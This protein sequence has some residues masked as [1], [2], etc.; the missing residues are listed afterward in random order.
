MK[1]LFYPFQTMME[2]NTA[3][4]RF[5][6][7]LD[8]NNT[9]DFL[10]ENFKHTLWLGKTV[11]CLQMYGETCPICELSRQYYNEKNE[12]LG[13][14]L[15]RSKSYIGQVIVIESPIKHDAS[16]LVKLIDIRPSIFKQIQE[17][18]TSNN[19]EAS[20]YDYHE[21]YNFYI[22][23]TINDLGEFSYRTSSFA[24]NQ[25]S[26]DNKIIAQLSLYNLKEHRTPYD[27]QL[28]YIE[29]LRVLVDEEKL[30]LHL[31]ILKQVRALKKLMG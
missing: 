7:D 11:P 8:K 25:S 27:S 31:N 5:L 10:V 14:K 12:E 4:V 3:I 19:L 21:G 30:K 18:F 22:R 24:P 17:A 23:K 26:I 28:T 20:P 13:K 15:F 1:D 2:G 16:Q 6:P 9:L 29:L